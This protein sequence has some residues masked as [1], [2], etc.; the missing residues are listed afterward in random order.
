MHD[1][2]FVDDGFEELDMVFQKAFAR[3]TEGK[4]RERHNPEGNTPFVKQPILEIARRQG[5]G[6]L[7][8][9][10]EKKMME[11]PVLLEKYSYDNAINELLDV[12]VYSAAAVI[13]LEEKR[14]SGEFPKTGI[15]SADDIMDMEV[16]KFVKCLDYVFKNNVMGSRDYIT[17]MVDD[18]KS[19]R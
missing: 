8:G 13:Y 2:V 15:D 14:I 6:Y 10:A 7:T 17:K 1:G 12:M 4:G 16:H 5:L 9:Q 18:Y 19:A 3:V 11:V